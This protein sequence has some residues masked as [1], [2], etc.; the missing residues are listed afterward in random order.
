MNLK[1]KKRNITGVGSV[2]KNIN[3]SLAVLFR[4][5]TLIGLKL[6]WVPCRKVI[7]GIQLTLAL[8]RKKNTFLNQAIWICVH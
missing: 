2:Q 8:C 3:L 6:P 5:K 1:R 4:A 7:F